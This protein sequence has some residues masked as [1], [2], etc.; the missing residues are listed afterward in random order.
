MI[1]LLPLN[2]KH[3]WQNVKYA[4]QGAKYAFGLGGDRIE[5]L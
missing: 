2:D 1:D 4:A 5:H 3:L